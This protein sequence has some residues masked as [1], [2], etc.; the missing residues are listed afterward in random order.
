MSVPGT[1]RLSI[2][3]RVLG[4]ATSATLHPLL[5]RGN[6]APST[7]RVLELL[8]LAIGQSAR[9]TALERIRLGGVDVDLVTPA[10]PPTAS[11][12]YFHGG[13]YVSGSP[14]SYRRLLTHL[15]AV[16]GCRV[17]AV[18]YRLAPEHPFPA[19]IDDGVA[20]CT[21]V[22]GRH[23]AEQMVI[24]GD[25]AGGGLTLAAAVALRDRGA[26]MPAALVCIAPWVDL[27][28]SGSSMRSHARR[29]RMMTP[30]GLR[31][32]ARR[33]AGDT[34]PRDPAISPLF[35]DLRGLPPLLIQVGDD[36]VLLD[37]ALRL[38][39]SAR[40]SGVEV[41]L[42]VWPRLWHVWHLYAGLMPEADAAVTAIADFIAGHCARR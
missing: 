9:G 38:A 21:A 29:E 14:R 15:A 10:V 35:A 40:D 22:A 28:C 26:A 5:R 24:A 41:T 13:A 1:D 37:D 23:P 33:Y 7:R 19:A 18:D 34:D 2:A 30:A 32:D 20:A 31:A 11:I 36:E 39:D 12:V 3:G 8:G 4:L 17:Y 6:A 42:Q 16:T 27:T 25:S